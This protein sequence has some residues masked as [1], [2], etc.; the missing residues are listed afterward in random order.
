MLE[1]KYANLWLALEVELQY[2]LLNQKQFCEF[3]LFQY[4][5]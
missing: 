5:Q 3:Q 4:E 2:N 1:E